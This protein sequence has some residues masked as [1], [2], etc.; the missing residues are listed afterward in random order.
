MTTPDTSPQ[1][2]CVIP[3]FNE[4]ANLR[5][6]LPRLQGFLQQR[7]ERWEIVLVDDGSGDDTAA[8]IDEWA[9]RCPQFRALQLSRNFGKEAALTAGLEAASGEVLVQLDADLQHPPELIDQMLERW[10][11]G[12]DVVYAVREDRSDERALKRAGV[13]LFYRLIQGTD[14]FQVPPNAGDFRLMDRQVVDA[15]L[16]LPERNRFMKG[17]YAWVGYRAEGLPYVPAERASGQ[18][19]FNLLRLVRFSIDGITGFTTWPLRVVSLIG[20][21]LALLSFL[22]GAYL[23]VTYLM[24]GNEV[25][26]WTTVVV[27]LL[28]FAGIQMVSIGVLGEYVARIFEEVKGRPL[29]L[30]RRRIGRE[31]RR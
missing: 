20:V 8:V 18:T 5:H 29:Y 14:R 21:A 27:C 4:A 31:G 17:L 22:Y 12:A 2:S 1:I 30:V 10:R 13:K 23:I 11:A 28:L 15:L 25:P 16:Q 19:S 26:G 9:A 24:Y 3:A 7:F 6:L